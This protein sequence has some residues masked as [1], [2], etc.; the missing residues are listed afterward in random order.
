MLPAPTPTKSR[1]TSGGWF[2]SDKNDRVVAA[3]C[4][5]MM[6]AMIK[7]SG[8]N[9]NTR[10]IAMS[11]IT[12]LGSVP[13]ISPSTATPRLSSPIRIT[14][15][16]AAISPIS[17]P[18]IRT[19]IR[20]EIVTRASTPTPMISVNILACGNSLARV[21]S[22]RSMA[23]SGAGNPRMAGSCEIRM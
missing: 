12:S 21:D 14:A 9:C 4:T 23:P 6:T 18:G 1:L 2:G 11:G 5:M 10:P 7:A 19:S 15:A 20:S 16:A 3:V 8:T 17:A 13:G 22:R